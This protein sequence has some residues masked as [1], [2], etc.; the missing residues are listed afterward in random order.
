MRAL[1]YL[2]YFFSRLF[3]RLELLLDKIIVGI[4][5]ADP[6]IKKGRELVFNG[7][8]IIRLGKNSRLVIGD[9]CRFNDGTLFNYIGR[10]GKCLLN[11]GDNACIVI[12]NN[13]GM[14]SSA[15]VAKKKI[16]I[17]ENVRIGGNVVIYDSDFHS[18]K[19][20]HRLAEVDNDTKTAPVIIEDNVF[21][22]AHSTILK[23]V[24]IGVNS[25][26]GACS[27]VTKDIPANQIWAGNPARFIRALD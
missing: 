5:L 16:V 12:G 10:D 19:P 2:Y 7:L 3:R 22:G 17:G 27:V 18:L 24:T 11:V 23:G 6:R 20:Q 26:I 8:P 15:L 25:V 1:F 21:I 13:S 9:N 4:M 14:S